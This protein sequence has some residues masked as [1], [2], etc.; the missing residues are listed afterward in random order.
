MLNADAFAVVREICTD[1]HFGS[2]GVERFMH[3]IIDEKI[4]VVFICDK[5][6]ICIY[7]ELFAEFKILCDKHEI[8]I[9]TIE[10]LERLTFKY[11]PLQSH[12]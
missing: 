1:K 6:R 8:N 2:S 12:D 10:Y 11:F 7:E 3:Q 4:N 5:I 9:F